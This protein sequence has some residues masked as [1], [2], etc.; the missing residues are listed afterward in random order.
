MQ[1]RSSVLRRHAA[2]NIGVLIATLL[3]WPA[4]S[5]AQPTTPTAAQPPPAEAGQPTAAE[6]ENWRKELLAVPRPTNGCYTV[7]YPERQ[8]REVPCKT[9]PNKPYLPRAGEITRLDKVVG[10]TGPDFSAVVTGNITQAE[11]SFDSVTG[12]T[13]TPAYSLQLNTDFF[14]TSTWMPPPNAGCRGW[15]QFVYDFS[16]SASY[17]TG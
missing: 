10:G 16:G 15:E 17:N 12:V 3:A 6:R 7:T 13:A 9:P 2:T 11:G 4:V 8:W 14:P 1:S 5:T